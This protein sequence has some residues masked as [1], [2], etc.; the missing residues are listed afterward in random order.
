MSANKKKNIKAT[1]PDSSSEDEDIINDGNNE[2]DKDED[3]ESDDSD[4]MD[5][6]SFEGNEVETPSH[7]YE[8]N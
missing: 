3:M 5:A 1:E 2:E 4:E 8:L 7:L 6:E